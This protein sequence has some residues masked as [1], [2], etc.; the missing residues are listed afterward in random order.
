MR[1]CAFIFLFAV[2][3]SA[4]AKLGETPEQIEAR[5]GKHILRQTNE[6]GDFRHYAWHEHAVKILFANGHSIE[7]EIS[8]TTAKPFI[9]TPEMLSFAKTATGR[10]DWKQT[11]F[12]GCQAIFKAGEFR[13]VYAMCKDVPTA[14]IVSG[15]AFEDFK[16]ANKLDD[17]GTSPFR[18]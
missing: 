14:V 17:K 5:Y 16:A 13:V 8:G 15:K 2:I 1:L 10:D 11:S 4:R 12:S 9:E 6:L 3:V 18:N 7:E